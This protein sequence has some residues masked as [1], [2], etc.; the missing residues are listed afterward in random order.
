MVW[1]LMCQIRAFRYFW[2]LRSAAQVP[3][4]TSASQDTF[5]TPLAACNSH[6]AA[7]MMRNSGGG[8]RGIRGIRQV[9]GL[10]GSDLNL[11]S[12]CEN[13]PISC[14][15][16]TGLQGWKEWGKVVVTAWHLFTADSEDEPETK[17]EPTVQAPEP[18]DPRSAPPGPPPPPQ[19]IPSGGV[20][21][22]PPPTGPNGTGAQCEGEQDYI[23]F[24]LKSVENLVAKKVLKGFPPAPTKCLKNFPIYNSCEPPSGGGA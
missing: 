11:Y 14:R 24:I 9:G 10:Q 22:P 6:N 15:D 16:S 12:Y 20:P 2:P 13:N 17:P 18:P 23:D 5:I 8:S 19:S 7:L 21:P 4:A 1:P 3:K